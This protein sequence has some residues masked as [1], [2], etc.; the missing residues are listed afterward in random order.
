MI[1]C[2][3][4]SEMSAPST[5][6]RYT[7]EDWL[8]QPEKAR[9]ELVDG[10]LIQKASPSGEHSCD[11]GRIAGLL[12]GA[13]GRRPAGP[14]GL[15]GW[16]FGTEADIKLG[17]NGFR[18]DV[19]GWR[20]DRHAGRP[21]GKPV[22]ARPDWICEVLSDSNRRHDTKVKLRHYH[23]AGIDHYWIVDPDERTLTVHRHTP[24][25]YLV[26]LVAYDTERVRAEPFGAVE[27][28]VGVMLGDDEEP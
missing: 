22:L 16:W 25:G 8:A 23:R 4:G 3:P 2:Y 17:D 28:H 1:P 13:F 7:I 12:D 15:G 24:E 10:E 11:Q 19:A 9:F 14:D 20:R 27:L 21:T 26:V 6:G 18:P 5:R